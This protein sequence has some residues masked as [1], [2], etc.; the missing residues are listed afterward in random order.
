M[1]RAART[2]TLV[3][4][5]LLTLFPGL[6]FAA[7]DLAL[8]MSVDVPVPAPGQPVQF[9]VTLTNV[10][11][12][13]ATAVTVTDKLPAEL[14]I[15]TGLAAF[16]S[17]GTYDP[18]SGAWVVGDLA[19]GASAQLVVPAIV[20]ATAVPPCSVNVAETN[21]SLDTQQA[22]NRAV[23]A[24]RRTATDRCVDLSVSGSG[25]VLPVCE[26]SRHLEL[27]VEVRNAGPDAASNVLVDLSQTPVIAPGLRFTSAGCSGTRCT[28]AS[29]APGST[30]SL[31]ARSND[32]RNL[33]QQTLK[34]NFAASSTET[35]Y[36]T[37]NN[38]ATAST[39]LT[40]FDTCEIDLGGS[41]IQ[42][43]IATAAYGSALEPQVVVLRAFR[44]RYL[45]HTAL[46]RAFIRFYYRHSPP[47]A[48]FIAAHPWSRAGTR[49][50]LTPIVLTIAYPLRT[51]A[52]IAFAVVLLMSW[53]L[54][55]R[56]RVTNGIGPNEAAPGTF[57]GRPTTGRDSSGP[58]LR[59]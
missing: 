23:A 13:P 38:Q 27:Q 58:L 52:V 44:D 16:A 7:P 35:D 55:R 6:V 1:I 57:P 43:F 32:F 48:S 49:A 33:T 56:R 29:M 28:I 59:R 19:A 5:I 51:L 12:D 9:T 14:A 45:Q 30:V 4:A 11:A 54:R 24:V 40:V 21:H 42:C 15:P 3:A 22:N 34:L 31:Q 37:D 47:L 25:N 18:V 2:R 50:L 26:K 36:E 41:T 39:L 46:G 53:R 8:S 10:G 20:V 17:V